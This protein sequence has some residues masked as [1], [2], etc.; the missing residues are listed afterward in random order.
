M[1]ADKI[2]H[3]SDREKWLAERRNSIGASDCPAIMGLTAYS[4]PT[5]VQADKWG[6]LTEDDE[7][8]YRWGNVFEEP[9][10]A[11]F[12]TETG[13]ETGPCGWLMRDPKR[14]WLH[15]TPDGFVQEHG[16]EE[17]GVVFLQAKWTAFRADDWK[18]GVPEAVLAQQQAEM[19]VTGHDYCYVACLAGHDLRWSRIDADLEFQTRW[20]DIAEE[21]WGRTQAREPIVADGDR[22]THDALNAMYSE[23]NGELRT[24]GA[25]WCDRDQELEALKG[26]EKILKARIGKLKAEI[27][28]EIGS[29]DG[30]VMPDGTSYRLTRST[31][32]AYEVKAA[33]VVTLR[34][35]AAK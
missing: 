23:S 33:S 28:A 8:A 13:K 9:I 14:P 21:F 11:A 12:G 34:R 5:S 24:V 2:V 20:L 25:E 1:A 10:I 22:A 18:E 4:S 16:Y 27:K 19:L 15:A 29:G 3:S 17:G 30:I 6:L 35:K 7:K 32:K 31:R 26:E